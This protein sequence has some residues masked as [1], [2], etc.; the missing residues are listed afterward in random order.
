ML[1]VAGFDTDHR[2]VSHSLSLD[3]VR[4]EVNRVCVKQF[5]MKRLRRNMGAALRAQF[6]DPASLPRPETKTQLELQLCQAFDIMVT[7]TSEEQA[8]SQASSRSG[9]LIPKLPAIVRAAHDR[10]VRR[11]S[12]PANPQ[13]TV[14]AATQNER[15]RILARGPDK[16]ARDLAASLRTAR[17]QK[18]VQVLAVRKGIFKLAALAKRWAAPREMAHLPSFTGAP[19]EPGEVKTRELMQTWFPDTSE[20]GPSPLDLPLEPDGYQP[21]PPP[22]P[23]PEVPP[24]LPPEPP[25]QTWEAAQLPS[26]DGSSPPKRKPSKA[27]RDAPGSLLD[28]EL[29]GVVKGLPVGKS[30]LPD[31]MGNEVLKATAEVWVPYLELVFDACVREGYHPARFRFAITC[32]VKKASKERYDR[33]ESWRPIALLSCLGKV[34]EKIMANRCKAFAQGYGLIPDTQFSAPGRSAAQAIEYLVSTVHRGWCMDGKDAWK[35]SCSRCVSMITL[36][37]KRA[38]DRVPRA[39]LLKVLNSMGFPNYMV[40]YIHSFLSD[41]STILK[42]PGYESKLWWIKIGIPQGSP[43]SPILFILFTASLLEKLSTTRVLEDKYPLA[44]SFCFGYADDNHLV[45]I[46]DSF[47]TNC[48]IMEV[49]HNQIVEWAVEHSATLGPEKYHIIH[50]LQRGMCCPLPRHMASRS[51]RSA[52]YW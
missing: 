25:P 3:I 28:G 1:D 2:V 49:L 30:S 48:R 13:D 20:E 33:P 7:A 5:N 44:E 9:R 42:M 17:W 38:F 43:L 18:C 52:P 16:V 15:Q 19:N 41:R 35:G 36:D 22:E 8:R 31:G 14:G 6:G 4:K 51:L 27:S 45:I 32:V 34:L 46:S 21:G 10:A 39:T 40:R 47:A 26:P 50:F 29:M 24:E 23:P 11:Q 12:R 37:M